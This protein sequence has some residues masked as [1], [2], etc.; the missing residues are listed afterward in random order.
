[1]YVDRKF[2]NDF[3]IFFMKII[4]H[5]FKLI[6]KNNFKNILFCSMTVVKR[7]ELKVKS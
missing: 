7:I 2:S 6:N 1:M 5:A 3:F 4:E